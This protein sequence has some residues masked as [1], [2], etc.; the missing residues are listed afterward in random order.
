MD[1]IW[2]AHLPEAFGYGLIAYGRSEAEAKKLLKAEYLRWKKASGWWK[3]W[4]EAWEYFGG[5]TSCI[6]AGWV[7]T[8]GGEP[9]NE[10]E[11]NRQLALA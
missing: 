4:P 3:T 1:P 9:S 5:Y 2:K 8:E 10:D 6:S 11:L 7:G